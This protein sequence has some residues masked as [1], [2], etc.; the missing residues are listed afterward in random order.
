[1][2]A[3]DIF[4]YVPPALGD[5]CHWKPQFPDPPTELAFSVALANL[6]VSDGP[7]TVTDGLATIVTVIIFDTASSQPLPVHVYKHRKS[8][9]AVNVPVL[10][11]V[12]VPRL[13]HVSPPSEL[14]CHCLPQPKPPATDE[15]RVVE[16]PVH[17]PGAP[18]A[19]NEI[20]M[21]G[22]STWNTFTALFIERSQFVLPFFPV[23]V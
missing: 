9:V 6:Q 16:P 2:V 4:V 7:L 8:D 11:V 18:P 14:R 23:S 15:V 5:V 12:P 20:L 1:L 3:P 22:S 13:T 21:L 17:I 19:V 10:E